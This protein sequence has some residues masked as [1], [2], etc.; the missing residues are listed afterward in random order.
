MK[1]V[2]ASNNAHK[3]AEIQEIIAEEPKVE[4][5]ET[6]D[7]EEPEAEVVEVVAEES[8]VEI[9]EVQET[10]VKESGV[11][12]AEVQE[13]V[14]EESKVETVEEPKRPSRSASGKTI[15]GRSASRRVSDHRPGSRR[16]VEE[17][18]KPVS[19]VG[20]QAVVGSMTGTV[21]KSN[22]IQKTSLNDRKSTS[23]RNGRR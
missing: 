10:V 5:E 23:D 22:V 3:I 20:K 13:D 19:N 1:L 6:T 18:K 4:V 14:I 9:A 21:I 7:A 8:K 17:P 15:A 12:I 16:K 11:E 2:I